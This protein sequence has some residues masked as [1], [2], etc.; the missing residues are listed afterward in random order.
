MKYHLNSHVLLLSVA[1]F[2]SK[3]AHVMCDLFECSE[4]GECVRLGFISSGSRMIGPGTFGFKG[5]R[6]GVGMSHVLE[7]I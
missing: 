2:E 3:I 5:F 7:C 1:T 6:K 4:C